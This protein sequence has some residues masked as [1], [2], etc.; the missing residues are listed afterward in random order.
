MKHI[1]LTMRLHQSRAK[2]IWYDSEFRRLRA[3]L[4]FPF[5]SYIYELY[6]QAKDY[7]V[8][9]TSARYHNQGA[10]SSRGGGGP[11]S[12][13]CFV[14]QRTGT[15]TRPR[16]SYK[17]ECQT[18]QGTHPTRNCHRSANAQGANARQGG[19]VIALPA[20]VQSRRD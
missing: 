12:G 8:S 3:E 9:F 15:C 18:C 20:R 7:R 11:G 6:E 2:W 1:N 14:F 4:K 16:C 10:S 19:Q 13:T 17:H 5:A